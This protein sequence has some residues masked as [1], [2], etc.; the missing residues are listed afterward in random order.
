[1]FIF[2]QGSFAF[3]S[4]DDPLKDVFLSE[5]RPF[6]FDLD[7]NESRSG[8]NDRLGRNGIHHAIQKVTQEG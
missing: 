4:L 5:D 1:L 8:L 7:T 3:L 6:S 2:A